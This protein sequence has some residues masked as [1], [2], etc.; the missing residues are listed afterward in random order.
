MPNRRHCQRQKRVGSIA[1]KVI[2][3]LTRME[4]I[5]IFS[6]VEEPTEWSSGIVVV[7][8]KDRSVRI[9]VHVNLV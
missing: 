8:K 1:L 9:R 2:H 7:Q 4:D 3:E 6:R 5:G